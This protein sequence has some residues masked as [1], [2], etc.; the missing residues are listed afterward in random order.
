M[1][2]K[3]WCAWA[4]FTYSAGL[5]SIVEVKQQDEYLSCDISN[6]IRMYTDGLDSISL[7][8]EGIRYFVRDRKS[9]V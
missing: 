6:P 3:L 5:E 4:G 8:G 7:D 9:V 1:K 2:W